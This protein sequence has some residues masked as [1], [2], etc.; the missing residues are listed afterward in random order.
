MPV[1]SA[2]QAISRSRDNTE[3]YV[4]LMLGKNFWLLKAM[5]ILYRPGW[6]KNLERQK[7]EKKVWTHI[8]THTITH[9]HTQTHTH[10]HTHRHTH[11]HTHSH[12]HTHAHTHTHTHTHIYVYI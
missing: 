4:S 8:H 12:T 11:T 6:V 5:A 1:L 9:T 2:F 7:S 10:R 3:N